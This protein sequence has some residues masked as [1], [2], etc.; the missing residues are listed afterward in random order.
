MSRH[1]YY[2]YIF[3]YFLFMAVLLQILTTDYKQKDQYLNL[4]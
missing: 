3:K 1:A 2:I 4:A